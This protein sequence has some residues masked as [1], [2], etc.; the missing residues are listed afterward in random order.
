M[1]GRAEFFGIMPVQV[2]PPLR[3]VANGRVWRT[4]GAKGNEEAALTL[5]LSS[6]T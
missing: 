3:Q 1:C 5:H 2:S 6:A 4:Q